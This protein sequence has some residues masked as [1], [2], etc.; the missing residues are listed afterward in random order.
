[1]YALTPTTEPRPDGSATA[2]VERFPPSGGTY[3]LPAGG[4]GRARA[5]GPQHFAPAQTGAPCTCE[6]RGF[7]A[8][9]DA[10]L[11]PRGGQGRTCP[12]TISGTSMATPHVVGAAAIYASENPSA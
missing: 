6:K 2:G 12:D 7:C 3:G 10:P 8:G 1:M 4:P 11:R 9:A 5:Q